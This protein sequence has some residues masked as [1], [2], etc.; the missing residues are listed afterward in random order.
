MP[1]LRGN[2][3]MV[4]VKIETYKGIDIF[5][6]KEN[7]RLNFGFEGREVEA[8]YLFEAEQVIDEP[9]WEECNLEG[10]FLDGY[11]DRHIGLAKAKRKNKKTSIPDWLL[12]GQYDVEYKSSNRNDE[13]EVF[14]TNKENDAIYE[15][16]V[17]QRDIYNKELR[18]LNEIAGNLTTLA[19]K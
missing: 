2:N 8:K 14:P 16:W 18:K 7:G 5:Y 10:Y 4:K 11:I 15:Q 13:K 9:F 6:N 1:S 12:K 17:I 19:G 3:N